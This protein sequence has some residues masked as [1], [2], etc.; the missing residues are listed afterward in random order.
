MMIEA[1]HGAKLRG[2]D[3]GVRIRRAILRR[4]GCARE[5][6]C[7]RDVLADGFH[8]CEFFCSDLSKR[9]FRIAVGWCLR[10]LDQLENRLACLDSR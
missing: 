4:A 9:E 7:N 5:G 6:G 8:E 3:R 10:Q 2:F 1:G